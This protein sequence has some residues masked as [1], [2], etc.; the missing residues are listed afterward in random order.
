MLAWKEGKL[1]M[2][3]HIVQEAVI[4]FID[5]NETINSE[6]ITTNRVNK[7]WIIHLF[8]CKI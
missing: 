7:S 4:K 1:P 8:Q 6:L 3:G 2:A 5:Y